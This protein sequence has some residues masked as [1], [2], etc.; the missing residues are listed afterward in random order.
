M[1]SMTIVI[2]AALATLLMAPYSKADDQRVRPGTTAWAQSNPP[3]GNAEDIIANNRAHEVIVAVLDSGIDYQHPFLRRNL[4]F[5]LNE[6]VPYLRSGSM[7]G[8]DDNNGVVD[9]F[10]GY[11]FTGADGIPSH[12]L[13]SEEFGLRIIVNEKLEVTG[14]GTHVAGI[15]T[16]GDHRIGIMPFRVIPP[17]PGPQTIKEM[18]AQTADIFKDAIY[19]AKRSGARVVNMSLGIAP[20]EYVSGALIKKVFKEL[21]RYVEKAA[22][23]MVIVVAAG[24]DTVDISAGTKVMPCQLRAGNVLCVGSVNA[25]NELSDFSNRGLQYIDLFAPGEDILSTMPTDHTDDGLGF[26]PMSGTSMAAPYVA[27]VVA[28]VMIKNPCLNADQ[29]TAILVDTATRHKTALR[30]GNSK[31]E[32]FRYR[33]VDLKAAERKAAV[34]ECW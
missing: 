25:K 2:A 24:N 29:V 11:D 4:H 6:V 32:E 19:M 1:A 13:I 22:S 14:H 15:V 23:N 21:Q 3:L 7:G 27:H 30:L 12:R 9:D 18:V 8:D 33:V 17:P 20:S 28:R 34:T 26:G 16:Q 10:L 31:H 5:N